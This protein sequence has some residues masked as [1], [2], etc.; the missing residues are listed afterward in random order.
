VAS[1]KQYR[2]VQGIVEFPPKDGEAGGKTVRNI[3]V[4]Q[5][6]FKEQAIRVYATLWPSHAGVAVE[7]GDVVTLRGSYV[8]NVK[9]TD[10]ETKTYHNLSV[11]GILVHGRIDTGVKPDT[12]SDD[13]AADAAASDDDIPF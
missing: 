8:R 2:T 4:S 7:E 12:T 5:T 9:T 10:G 11:S 6:G 13:V 1:D 3:C